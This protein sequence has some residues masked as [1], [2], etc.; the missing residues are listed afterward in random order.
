MRN[1]W[2]QSPLNLKQLLMLL[3]AQTGI[4]KSSVSQREGKPTVVCSQQL[5][6]S[7]W[8]KAG[9][10]LIFFALL[11]PICDAKAERVPHPVVTIFPSHCLTCALFFC[12]SVFRVVL[13]V[14]VNAYFPT[15]RSS[16]ALWSKE[17]F[18]PILVLTTLTYSWQQVQGGAQA[19]SGWKKKRT[20][21]ER[22]G[23]RLIDKGKDLGG[24][25]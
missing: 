25:I 13:L 11:L 19:S 16:N 9:E 22:E 8:G 10:D 3:L 12:F 4:Y 7:E 23:E 17:V 5:P 18:C 1:P 14:T 6:A 15:P 24:E 20:W 21:R 2:R